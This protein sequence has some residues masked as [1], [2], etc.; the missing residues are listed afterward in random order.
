MQF[1][2]IFNCQGMPLP[3]PT[4]TAQALIW[5][6]QGGGHQSDREANQYQAF[7]HIIN[8]NIFMVSIKHHSDQTN[9][10]SKIKDSALTF[11]QGKAAEA[12]FGPY[13]PGTNSFT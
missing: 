3:R 7:G 11:G 8:Y 9:K 12:F 13:P 10:Y 1:S 2:R 4:K 6:F 5:K